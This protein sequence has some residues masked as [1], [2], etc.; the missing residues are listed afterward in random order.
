M[1]QFAYAASHDLKSPLRAIENLAQWT[2]E[3]GGADLPADCLKNLEKILQRAK[4][5][6]TLQNDLLEYSRAGH[7]ADKI[8][9]IDIN[10]LVAELSEF[11]DP[12][13]RFTI[14]VSGASQVIHTSETPLRQVLMNLLNNAIKHHDRGYGI[15]TISI[16]FSTSR[17]HVSMLDDGPGI[18]EQYLEQIFELFNMLQTQDDVEGSGLGLALVRKLVKRYGGTITAVSNPTLQR[19]TEFQFDWPIHINSE[20]R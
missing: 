11:L 3:D 1:E 18:E 12:D 19:G 9:A 10:L 17:M 16:H 14:E 6:S 8:K 4:R 5:L 7:A 13:S 20:H 15:V 2:I